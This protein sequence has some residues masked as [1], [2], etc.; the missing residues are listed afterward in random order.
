MRAKCEMGGG[1]VDGSSR[2]PIKGDIQYL[3]IFIFQNYIRN[4]KKPFNCIHS[5]FQ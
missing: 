4:F 3:S 1:F 2:S 5:K